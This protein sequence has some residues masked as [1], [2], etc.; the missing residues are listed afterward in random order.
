M[1]LIAFDLLLVQ[2]LSL[3][4]QV[5]NTIPV[6]VILDKGCLSNTAGFIPFPCI[7]T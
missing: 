6:L 3:V 4:L 2:E 5:F 1:C 7:D